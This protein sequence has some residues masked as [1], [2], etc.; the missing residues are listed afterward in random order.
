MPENLKEYR[1]IV[2]RPKFCPVPHWGSLYS[3]LYTPLLEEEE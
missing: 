1:E 2:K 3:D